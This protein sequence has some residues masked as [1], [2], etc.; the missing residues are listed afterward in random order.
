M[1]ALSLAKLPPKDLC[2]YVNVSMKFPSSLEGGDLKRDPAAPGSEPK[3][4]QLNM[5]RC[6]LMIVAPSVLTNNGC[7]NTLCSLA[8]AI[9][10]KS[11]VALW[12]CGTRVGPGCLQGV[13]LP[14]SRLCCAAGLCG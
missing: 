5:Y 9:M 13:E 6:E 4:L 1:Q 14:S 11:P 12:E 10:K 2:D 7:R 3:D 8:S